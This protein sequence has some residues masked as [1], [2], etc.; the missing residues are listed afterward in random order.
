MRTPFLLLLPTLV[1]CKGGVVN[2]DREAEAAAIGLEGAIE[3]ALGLGFD[4]FAAA[5][6]ANIPTQTGSGDLSGTMTVSGQVDQGNSDNKG[7][8]LDV[9]LDDYA[10]VE[11]IETDEIDAVQVAYDTDDAALPRFDLS[12][13][14]IPDGTM[15]GTVT[16]TFLLS[17]DLEGELSLSLALDGIIV[18][19]GDGTMREEGT[20]SVTGTATNSGGGTFDVDVVL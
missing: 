7:M 13:R 2:S 9:A 11:T 1:A 4:G 18:P 8:R 14:D 6:S 3:R 12:L 5:S 15:T 20:T 19:D 17:G 16:G 10:D